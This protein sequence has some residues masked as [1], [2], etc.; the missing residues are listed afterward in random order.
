MGIVLGLF[1]AGWL[2][3]LCGRL[4]LARLRRGVVLRAPCCELPVALLWAAS[5]TEPLS[6]DGPPHWLPVLLAVA[7]C[8]VLLAAV[9]LAARRLPDVLTVAALLIFWACLGAAAWLAARPELLG[10]AV[11]GMCA[12]FLAHLAVRTLSPGALGAGDVKL[13]APLGAVLGAVGLPALAVAAVLAAL[14]TAVLGCVARLLR[15]RAWRTGVPHGPGL[16]LATWLLAALPG[17]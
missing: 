11:L 4:L 1:V 8:G 3:G 2:A 12:F 13:A 7:L 16:V 5:A 10:R 9:D 17:A 6:R 14:V 15:H